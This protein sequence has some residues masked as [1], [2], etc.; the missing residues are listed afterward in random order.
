MT[1][2]RASRRALALACLVVVILIV[3]LFS[4][5][6]AEARPRLRSVFAGANQASLAR[7]G[8]HPDCNVTMP[9]QLPIASQTRAT[10]R[11]QARRARGQRIER[12]MPFG[13]AT[14]RQAKP[15]AAEAK[16]SSRPAP[17]IAGFIQHTVRAAGVTLAGVVSPLADKAREIQ[18]ACGA[19]VISA[20]RHTRIRG[21][22]IM[23]LHASGQA[24]D[25]SGDPDC[26][27]AQL[28]SWSG[29]YS[30][31]YARVK[32]VHISWSGGGRE[33]GARFAHG[34][35]R[36]VRRVRYAGAR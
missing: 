30:I 8:L 19:K 24:V 17:T 33:W 23:S 14:Q 15:V 18:T 22:R 35:R 25:M 7:A 13:R 3:L 26:I 36:A 34:G 4:L 27:Y 2:Q 5:R 32:H 20:V 6:A 11:E 28:R 12:A 31:D 29:G 16:S 1:I 9:C 21:T 10:R